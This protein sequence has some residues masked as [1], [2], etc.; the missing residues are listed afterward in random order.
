[1]VGERPGPGSVKR[2]FATN[3]NIQAGSCSGRG[4]TGTWICQEVLCY[5]YQYTGRQL[6]WSGNDRDLDLSRGTLLPIPI[7][8]P[9]AAVVGERPGPGS[10]YRYFATNTNIQAGSSGR[11]TTGA[12]ICLEVLC[13]QYQYTGRQ[14]QWSGN[15]RGLDLSRGTLLPIP[16]YR[17]A[18]AVVGER[19]GP[20]SV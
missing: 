13:Y 14:L 9:A 2:Y 1:M 8:R 16:I 17:P 6:Q 12:W 20:G 10:V 11:G 3:T 7:Y 18:A 5:Q 19:P 15:D 4:T